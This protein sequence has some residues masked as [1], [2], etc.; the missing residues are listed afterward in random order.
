METLNLK[1]IEKLGESPVTE[2]LGGVIRYINET[3]S[4]L[5]CEYVGTEE[6]R[7]P[8]GNLQGGMLSAMLDDITAWLVTVGLDGSAR[9]ATLSLN[10]SF[11]RPAN[12]GHLQ[13]CATM[14][15]RGRTVCHVNGELW[16]E[17]KLIASAT[18]VCAIVR[19]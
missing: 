6:F 4:R 1:G 12:P 14:V 8:A 2:M 9:C 7:N 17:G 3:C 15:R 18:A 5:E 11:I 13:G 16:Q 19:A 10:T